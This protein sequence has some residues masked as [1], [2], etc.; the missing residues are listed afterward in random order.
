VHATIRAETDLLEHRRHFKRRL[1]S[2]RAEL[3]EN[4]ALRG[5]IF[6]PLKVISKA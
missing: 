6:E 4:V 5:P 1:D 2:K 3:V